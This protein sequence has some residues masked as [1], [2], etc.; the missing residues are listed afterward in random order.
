MKKALALLAIILLTIPA[1]AQDNYTIS[2][3][4]KSATGEK[5]E[6][7][8][9]FIAGSQKVTMTN[10]NGQFAFR[11]ISSG[12]Y[13]LVVNMLGYSSIKQNVIINDK[14]ETI[15]ITLGEKQIVLK[16]VIV[17]GVKQKKVLEQEKSYLKTFIKKFMGE[18]ENAKACKIINPEI[19]EFSTSKGILKAATY[20]FLEIENVNL[21]YHIKYLLK[22]FEYDEKRDNTYYDGDCVFENLNGTPEQQAVWAANRKKTYDGSLMHFL[23]SVYANTSRQEGFLIY[24]SRNDLFPMTIAPNPVVAEQI[25]KHLDSNFIT[26]RFKKRLY[27]IY[28]KKKAAKE[29]KIIDDP[30]WI[31]SD[32]PGNASIFMVDSQV[33]RRGSYAD[34]GGLLIQGAWVKKRIGEQLPLEYVPQ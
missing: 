27:V 9:M 30:S 8:T 18:S 7:A 2:G 13:Q 33:D 20:D 4:V 11:S 32:L 24:L 23:R 10:A 15:D 25:I 5:I 19:I 34:H 26:F 21:G 17:G 28:D 1:Y 12:T 6:S 3:T 16:E 14:S 29:D 22:T 31:V